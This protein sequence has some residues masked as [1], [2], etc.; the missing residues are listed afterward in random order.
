MYRVFCLYIGSQSTESDL[1]NHELS[2]QSQLFVNSLN[3]HLASCM[4]DITVNTLPSSDTPEHRALLHCYHT[5]VQCISQSPKD[6]GDRLVPLGVLSSEDVRY[7]RN[8]LHDQADKAR[9]IID[10]IINHVQR[11]VTVYRN[12]VD[13]LKAATFTKDA[14]IE[15]EKAYKQS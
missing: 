8:D 11:N 2:L 4:S 5:L 15:L 1:A 3:S 12:F 7:L 9:R 10:V 6:I 14:V 13:A